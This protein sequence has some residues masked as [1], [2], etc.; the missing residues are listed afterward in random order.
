MLSGLC[1]NILFVQEKIGV[2]DD[3]IHRCADIVGHIK[4]K[5]SFSFTAFFGLYFFTPHDIVPLLQ[6]R[7]NVK[8]DRQTYGNDEH[9]NNAS[10]NQFC[11]YT[12]VFAFNFNDTFNVP[13]QCGIQQ[14]T[15]QHRAGQGITAE[16]CIR[17]V[18]YST[19]IE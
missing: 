14:Q 12:A 13:H 4:Q 9:K 19:P 15:K 2:A 17:C 16:F 11:A 6:L 8:H 10:D 7:L 1:G 3:S 18:A 5:T